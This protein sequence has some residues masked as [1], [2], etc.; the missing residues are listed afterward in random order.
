MDD[1]Y[2][3]NGPEL[4]LHKVTCVFERRDILGVLEKSYRKYM[5]EYEKQVMPKLKEE[6]SKIVKKTIQEDGIELFQLDHSRLETSLYSA[7]RESGVVDFSK[8]D[9]NVTDPILVSIKMENV[10]GLIGLLYLLEGNCTLF[11]PNNPKISI[12]NLKKLSWYPVGLWAMEHFIDKSI[13]TVGSMAQFCEIL[14]NSDIYKE[15]YE[16]KE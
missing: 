1:Y 6:I 9:I 13:W 16:V 4:G 14:E 8:W 3:I 11:V 15:I 5:E 12:L 2:K 7:H 10:D